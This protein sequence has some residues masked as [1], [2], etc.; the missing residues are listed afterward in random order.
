MTALPIILA[1]GICPFHRFF[2]FASSLDNAGSDNFHYFRNIRSTLIANGYT[3]FHVRVGWA[4][5]LEQR[6]ADLRN[7]ILQV[8]DHFR[9]WP[10]VHI[11]G[12][13][14]GG[15]DARHM[16]WRCAMA[17]RVVSLTTIG[18]P[19]WG[20]RY[21]DYRIQQAGHLIDTAGRLGLDITGFRDLTT[22]ACRSRNALLEDFEKNTSVVYRTVA[23]A[24]P[25]QRIFRPM[26]IAYRIIRDEEGENDGLVSVKSA[27]WQER[28]LL[29]VIDADHLNQIGWW[30]PGEGRAG[31]PREEFERGI[32]EVYLKLAGSLKTLE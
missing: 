5:C 14:M 11:I 21:A 8:T 23:G 12:H 18:T 20:T 16:I 19:H 17:D 28:F 4:S 22:D 24:Q 10:A 6:A 26:R 29:A 2:P 1:H 15:L 27:T 30:D 31:R 7:G 13:S 25:L 32:R 3:A 9:R